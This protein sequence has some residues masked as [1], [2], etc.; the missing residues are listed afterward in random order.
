VENS[1]GSAVTGVLAISG[2]CAVAQEGEGGKVLRH[3]VLFKFKDGTAPEKIKEIED[4]FRALP[5]KIET[6]KDFEWGI[7]LKAGKIG[8]GALR[9]RIR[10]KNSSRDCSFSQE[11][12]EGESVVQFLDFQRNF[13]HFINGIDSS[14][15]CGAVSGNS[16]CFDSHF[17]ST[18]MSSI[19]IQTG[20]F[21]ADDHFR[22]NSRLF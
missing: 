1:L 11:R 20:R 10:F 16:L 5:G 6:I 17:H 19:D 2:M 7:D 15:R 8:N 12:I 4:A 18:A 9:R 13:C 3:V 21:G 14:F 22:L